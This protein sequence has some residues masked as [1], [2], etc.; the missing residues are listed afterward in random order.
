MYRAHLSRE[1]RDILRICSQRKSQDLSL[2]KQVCSTDFAANPE[3]M[4]KFTAN[5][6]C[7]ITATNGG[8]LRE[9]RTKLIDRGSAKKIIAR[10]PEHVDSSASTARKMHRSSPTSQKVHFSPCVASTAPL[11]KSFSFSSLP[12]P[13]FRASPTVSVPQ[14]GLLLTVSLFCSSNFFRASSFFS[15][16]KCCPAGQSSV[17]TSHG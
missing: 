12:P 11:A 15:F 10:R 17:S 6:T 5:M 14:F 3:F 9:N 16:W 13:A 1:L 7:A 2:V 8:S 4:P